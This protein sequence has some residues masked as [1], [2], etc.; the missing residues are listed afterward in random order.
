MDLSRRALQ[1]L[2]KV[3]NIIVE[4]G[5]LAGTRALLQAAGIDPAGKRLL[6]LETEPGSSRERLEAFRDVVAR[7]ESVCLFGVAEGAPAF[8]DPGSGVIAEAGRL[9]VPVQSVGGPSA[10][11][12]ALMRLEEDLQEFLFLGRLESPSDV[13]RIASRARRLPD[14]PLVIFT[15]G[16]HCR[17]LLP[18]VLDHVSWT[19]GWLLADLTTDRELVLAL[20]ANSALPDD[21]FRDDARIVVVL[22][23]SGVRPP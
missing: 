5:T 19:R 9:G 21:R 18:D 10:L 16:G 3:P 23:G 1:I 8:V 6:E 12:Q 14:V 15:H 22:H 11:T 7:N 17:V 2:A 20:Q 13:D 4:Q